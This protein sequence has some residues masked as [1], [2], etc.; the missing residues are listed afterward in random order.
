MGVSAARIMRFYKYML[1]YS[2]NYSLILAL[3]QIPKV[4]CWSIVNP[5]AARRTERRA[6]D[7]TR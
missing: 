1:Y 2:R 3:I 4:Y 6:E 5:M 7:R